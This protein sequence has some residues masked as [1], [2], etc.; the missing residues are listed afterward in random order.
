MPGPASASTE[1]SGD[2]AGHSIESLDHLGDTEM[3]AIAA[4]MTMRR[5][6][7]RRFLQIT[8]LQ[9]DAGNDDRLESS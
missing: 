8:K 4:W 2:T 5:P 1:I 3:L 7:P 6:R 9:E